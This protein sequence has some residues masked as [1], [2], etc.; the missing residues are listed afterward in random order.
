MFSQRAKKLRTSSSSLSDSNYE[1]DWYLEANHEFLED[2]F[3]IQVWWK[4]HEHDYPIL[5]ITAKQ[6]LGTPVSTVTVEQEFS[7]GG[8]I[9]EP[10]PQSLEMQTCVD[11]WTKEKYIQQEL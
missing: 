6:I 10:R 11:D 8:N 7:A 3:S 9:L 2:K 1:L 5:A 4:G